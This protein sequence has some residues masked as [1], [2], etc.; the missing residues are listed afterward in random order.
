[1]ECKMLGAFDQVQLRITSKAVLCLPDFS[2]LRGAHR[3]VGLRHWQVLMQAGHSVTFGGQKFNDTEQW[4]SVHE[5]EMTVV[6]YCLQTWHHYLLSSHF[7]VFTDNV[8]AS[9]FAT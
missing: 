9:C 5:K 4:Y 8:A 7:T 1:M 6:V 3:H 2:L